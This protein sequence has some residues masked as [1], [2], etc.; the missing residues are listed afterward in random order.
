MNVSENARLLTP[1]CLLLAAGIFAIDI[2]VP[3]G[4][5][6]G[7]GYVAVVLIS[8]RS[9][10]RGFT[11]SAA[12][13][14]SA[15]TVAG[16]FWSP[17]GGIGWMVLSN[18]A[19]ALYAIWAT[20]LFGLQLTR[21]Y[22]ARIESTAK[23]KTILDAAVDAIITI[24][25]AGTIE[26]FSPGAERTFGYAS[27]EVL[28]R[29]V[30]M[31]MPPPYAEEHAGYLSSYLRTGQKKVI[32]IGREVLG[33]RKDGTTVPLHLSVAAVELGNRSFFAGYLHDLTEQK[34][35]ENQLQAAANAAVL[36][37]DRERREL[38]R[39]LHDDLGQLLALSSMK[40]GALRTAAEAHELAPRVREVEQLIGEAHERTTSLTFQLSPPVLHDVGIVGAAEWLSE[41]LERRYG[42]HIAIED[43]GLPKPLDEGPRVF[44]FRALRELLINVAKHAGVDKARV[45]FWR[46]GEVLFLV[47]EDG[48]SGFHP[49][50]TTEGY[51]LLS[52][53]AHLKPLSGEM[54][55][56]STLGE[57]TK[58]FLTMP[59]A[60]E[61]PEGEA[62][63]G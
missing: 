11:L 47:V 58:V 60:S 63:S 9:D 10:R 17:S 20:A 42:L 24:D 23:M 62:G 27:R 54:R 59:L 5:A 7:V 28:G 41:E 32:G 40:L 18:R 16:F 36:G 38:A 46:E 61:R 44:L 21:S 49:S 4:V 3:L 29:N 12:A 50:A 35:L 37:E 52:I 6:G 8:L 48:G 56:E 13:V 22:A 2:R 25:P 51:G 19:L 55:V 39:D 34:H 26:S 43:D 30:D 53:R 57:G 33:L 31:L 45:R 15:L 14:V 1:A